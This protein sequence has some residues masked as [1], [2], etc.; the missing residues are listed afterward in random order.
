M[1]E[2]RTKRNDGDVSSFLGAIEKEEQRNDILKICGWIEAAIG[3]KPA[4]WGDSIVGFGTYHYRY[5]TGREGDW[6]RIGVSPRKQAISLYLMA[7]FE[8]HEELLQRLGKFKMGKCCLYIK[9]LSDIDEAA[10]VELIQL[11]AK[12]KICSEV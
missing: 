2:L 8:E 12:A 3:G 5:A 7:G 10:L 6:F 9:R 1:S 11:S 4:M